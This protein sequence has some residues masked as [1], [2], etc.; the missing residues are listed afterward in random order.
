MFEFTVFYF[1]SMPN[2]HPANKFEIEG[3]RFAFN[4][5]YNILT[6][7]PKKNGV[8]AGGLGV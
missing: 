8:G 4:S 3:F 1:I 2:C 6:N 7:F 5:F